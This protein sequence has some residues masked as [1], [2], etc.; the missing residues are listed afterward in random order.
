MIANILG[1]RISYTKKC[2]VCNSSGYCR[3]MVVVDCYTHKP[4]YIGQRCGCGFER[5][6]DI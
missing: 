1:K 3:P 5:R 6:I 2:P 4:L